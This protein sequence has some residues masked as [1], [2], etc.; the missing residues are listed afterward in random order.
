[1][2]E[3]RMYVER[4]FEGR[5]LTAEMIELKEEIYGNL[6]ARYED[7]VSDGVDPEEALRRTKES[8][9]SI[10]D[11]LSEEEAV[12]T[13][14]EAQEGPGNAGEDTESGTGETTVLGAPDGLAETVPDATAVSP[15]VGAVARDAAGGG[16]VPPEGAGNPLP[17]PVETRGAAPRRKRTWLIVV[18]AIAAVLVVLAL[19]FGLGLV[20]FGMSGMGDVDIDEGR[21]EVEDASGNQVTIDPQQ[22]ITSANGKDEVTVDA[23]GKARLEGEPADDLLTEVVNTRSG[24]IKAF[25]DTDLSDAAGVESMLRSLPLH[26]WVGDIDLTR[27]VDVLSLSYR[28]VPDTY[29][30]ESV[31][32]ALAYNVA[33]L[34]CAMPTL[35]EVQVTMTESDEPADETYYVFERVDVQQRFGVRLD[36]NMVNEAGWGQIKRDHL[37][38]HDFAG[39]MVDAAERAWR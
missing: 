18:G 21:I 38:K 6:V 27:G 19:L 36:G 3:I 39:D 30:G 20:G 35:N 17:V 26:Q 12:Q 7:L 34:F 33:A 11:V 28:E 15:A 4:L 24:D 23:D 5:L 16:P 2:N 32:I 37:Y 9:V 22:G 31:D 10:D 25:V 1:M 13:G 14:Q 8:M 29:E